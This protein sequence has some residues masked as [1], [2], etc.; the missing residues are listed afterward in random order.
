[1]QNIQEGLSKLQMASIITSVVSGMGLAVEQ[2][3]QIWGFSAV[4]G[5]ISDTCA[6][7]VMASSFMLGG[8]TVGKHAVKKAI[9]KQGEA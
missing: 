4:A 8:S 5:Q 6:V 3:G 1:M 9:A 7:I 2:V